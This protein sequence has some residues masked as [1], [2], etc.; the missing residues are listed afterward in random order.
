[1]ENKKV[2]LRPLEREDLPFVHSLDN[3]VNVMRYWFEEPYE[4]LVELEDIYEKHI[5]DQSERRFI[6]SLEGLNI[7]LVE[8]VDIHQIHRNAEFQ[9]IIAQEHQG[10]HYAS[11][12]AAL[13]IDYSFRVLNLYKLYLIVDKE[14]EKAIHIYEKLG[15]EVEGVLRR[16]YYINGRYRDVIRMAIFRG[17]YLGAEDS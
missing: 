4:A 2:T 8:L 10:H 16:E 1:M 11:E 14:N 9:I 17:D 12:A 13:A 15:F 3:N 6:V 5:H 7:G